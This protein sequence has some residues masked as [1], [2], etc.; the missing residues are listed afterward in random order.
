VRFVI[1]T[2]EDAA[3][4]LNHMWLPT[5]LG[6]NPEFKKE[7]EAHVNPLLVG[8]EPTKEVLDEAHEEVIQFILK[9]F[10][11]IPGLEGYLRAVEHVKDR[12]S[13]D[14]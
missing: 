2:P 12:E 11:G 8:K 14:G 3:V 6:M 4:D 9:K 10:S 5:W 1:Y 13:Q 7:V